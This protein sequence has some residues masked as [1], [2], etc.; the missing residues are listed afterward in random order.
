M[1]GAVEVGRG[2]VELVLAFLGGG[3]GAL[4]QAGDFGFGD[5]GLK[6]R[7]ASKAWSR[8]CGL[9]MPVIC[10]AMGRLRQ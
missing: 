7:A 4:E 1:G 9:S 2:F 3:A 10:T 5:S 8:I 6:V